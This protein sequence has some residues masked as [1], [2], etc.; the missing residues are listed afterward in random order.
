MKLTQHFT[1]EE[2]TITE[3]QEYK[4]SNYEAGLKELYKL[5][6][7]AN[8]AEK[9]RKEI[10]SPMIITSGYRSE[11]LNKI[12]GGSKTSQHIKFEAIDFIPTKISAKEAFDK[13]SKSKL[14][15]GQLILEKR[16]LGH[17][18]H[19]SI[20]STRK[21]LYSPNLGHYKEV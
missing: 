15:F 13:L 5:C 21:T 4:Q 16:G 3:Q 1:A 10:N 9:V 12:I 14:Q 8:F 2:L 11:E 18:V 6:S 19:I 7:L 17:I 20:G